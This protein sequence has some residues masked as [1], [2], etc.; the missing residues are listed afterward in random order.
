MGKDSKTKTILY[1]STFSPPS[2]YVRIVF[3]HLKIRYQ[4]KELN[5]GTGEHKKAWFKKV[6]PK[7]AVPALKDSDG[8]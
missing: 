6:N 7:Q 1:H 4:D 3:D 8:F 5:I 2:L